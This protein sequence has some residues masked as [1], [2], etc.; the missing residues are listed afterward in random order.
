MARDKG[1]CCYVIVVFTAHVHV[2]G[3]PGIILETLS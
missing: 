2:F 1:N 3:L